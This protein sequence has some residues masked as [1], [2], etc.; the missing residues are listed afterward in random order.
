MNELG[1]GRYEHIGAACWSGPA[2]Y[3]SPARSGRAVVDSARVGPDGDCWSSC[4]PICQ[5]RRPRSRSTRS[6]PGSRLPSDFVGLSYEMRELSAACTTND[7]VGN[8]GRP[9]RQPRQPVQDARSE[10]RPHQRQPSST[11]TRCGSRPASNHRNPLPD[12]VKDVVT[13]ADIARLGTFPEGH[14]GG[15]PRWASTS[16]TTT[17][18]GRRRSAHPVRR[19]RPTA[20]GGRM[21]QRARQHYVSNGYRTAPYGFPRAQGGVGSVRR[22]G[23]QFA[24]RRARPQL[25]GQHCQL[26]QPVRAGRAGSHQHA[27]RSQLHRRHGRSPQLLS[28]QV[29]DSELS[30]VA[31]QA[32]RRPGRA[33]ADLG[34]TRPTPALKRWPG[35]CQ[36]HL[37]VGSVGDGLQP[38]DG[39]GRVS[40]G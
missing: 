37:R 23:G 32:G 12:W 24:N 11:A 15:R 3:G 1:G 25:A 10:Q 6:N 33:R 39:P 14:P 31:P 34:W 2:A 17:R 18:P 26:V 40:P 8:F 20:V 13:P 21:W 30:I 9:K 22:R 38:G 4:Q 36:Q 27:D 35:R 7:C 28:P 5:R 19:P 29:H 16:C